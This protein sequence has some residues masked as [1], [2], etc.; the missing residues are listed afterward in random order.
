M[1]VFNLKMELQFFLCNEGNAA[2]GSNQPVNKSLDGS[3]YPG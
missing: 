2:M 3:M 1:R